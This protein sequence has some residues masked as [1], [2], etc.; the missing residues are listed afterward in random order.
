[1][2]NLL[3]PA[4]WG[5]RAAETKDPSPGKKRSKATNPSSDEPDALGRIFVAVRIRPLNAR[6]LSDEDGKQPE[7]A[8][9]R[10]MDGN[11]VVETPRYQLPEGAAAPAWEADAVFGENDGNATVYSSAAQPV[12][13]A[14]LRGV[15]APST[16]GQT[17]SGKTHVRRRYRPGRMSLALRDIFDAVRA[18]EHTRRYDVR[19][20]YMEIYNEEI[21]DLLSRDPDG[22]RSHIKLVNG[23]NGLTQVLNLEE[24]VVESSEEVNDVVAAGLK[25]RQVGRTAMNHVSRSPVLRIKVASA[26]HRGRS[27]RGPATVSTLYVVDP[28]GG[29]RAAQNTSRRR[30]GGAAINQSLLTLRLCVQRLAKD[31]EDGAENRRTSYRDS[32]LTRI[33]QPALAGPGRT[34][35]VAA[36]TPA[37]GNAQ[38][39]Y[40]TLNFVGTAKSVKMDARVNVVNSGSGASHLTSEERKVLADLRANA[41]AEAIRRKELEEE[42]ERAQE[43]LSRVGAGLAE[44][45]AKVTEL[46]RA[47]EDARRDKEDTDRRVRELERR[48]EEAERARDARLRSF[49]SLPD[50]SRIRKP[51]TRRESR[52]SP[53]RSRRRVARRPPLWPPRRPRRRRAPR[54]RTPPQPRGS[55]RKS[56]NPRAAT[57]RW[58]RL[59]PKPRLRGTRR[60]LR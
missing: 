28:A 5:K 59:R 57:R 1:M 2:M 18:D 25:R 33:L 46:T 58:P 27:Q 24:R 20:S 13:R 54:R 8:V 38:E 30:R 7:V 6:E 40:S 36:V 17:S 42:H 3:S 15:T 56:P 31:A 48:A 21:R 50:R 4:R 45:E 16:G 53:R 23:H 32:K 52:S 9:F 55:R 47:T 35:I 60:R 39:T 22:N 12:V 51:A 49:W 29:E 11:K 10:A 14:V 44:A 19:C 41:A 37:A 43:E 34:A 26:S